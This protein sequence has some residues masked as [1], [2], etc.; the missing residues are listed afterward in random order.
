MRECP[1]CGSSMD[2]VR[3]IFKDLYGDNHSWMREECQKCGQW[4]G[5]LIPIDDVK[6]DENTVFSI[7]PGYEAL[8]DVLQRAMDR[9]QRGKGRERHFS[10]EPFN[11]QKICEITRR[12][13]LGFPLGQLEKKLDESERMARDAA[14][15]E[16]LDGIVYIAAAIIVMEGDDGNPDRT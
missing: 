4:L 5:E 13:G 6:N 2:K 9:S 16:L 15:N 1:I 8:H 14:V 12:V 11:R 3:R 10:G 7:E